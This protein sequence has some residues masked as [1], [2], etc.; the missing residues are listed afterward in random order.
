MTTRKKIDYLFN[1]VAELTGYPTKG[2]R[3]ETGK[4][5]E[6]YQ[7][8]WLKMDYASV[9]GGYRITIVMKSTGEQE[10]DS[11]DRK[12]AKEMLHYLRGLLKGLTFKK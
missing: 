9:Y 5:H 3:N 7:N 1:Q 6:Y 8:E 10:F 4:D 12:T 2:I 11:L